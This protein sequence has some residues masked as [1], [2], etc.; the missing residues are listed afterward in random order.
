M[1]SYFDCQPVSM[2]NTRI[3]FK[4]EDDTRRPT[5]DPTVAGN[6]EDHNDNPKDQG[7]LNDMDW[8][9][10]QS[11]LVNSSS[12]DDNA[13]KGDDDASD[14]DSDSGTNDSIDAGLDNMGSLL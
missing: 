6:P 5:D 2:F 11:T 1:A 9:D 14:T 4:N 13:S 3:K 12:Q 8:D 10:E 7:M